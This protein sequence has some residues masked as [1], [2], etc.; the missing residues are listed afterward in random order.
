[1]IDE[2]SYQYLNQVRP[3]LAERVIKILTAMSVLGYNM[4]VTSGNRTTEEQQ[5][6]YARGRTKPG[7]IVTH[8]DG[9]TRKSNHQ[10]GRAVDCTFLDI[11]GRPHWP[12]DDKLW[13]LYGSM[14]K[15]LGLIWGGDWKSL[16]DRPHIELPRGQ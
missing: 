1:M 9:I 11:N 4:T 3:E 10:D 5:S 15:A 8:L 6:L 13:S 7:K 16:V 14:A 2:R 12:E